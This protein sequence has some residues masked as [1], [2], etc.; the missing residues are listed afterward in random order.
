M[1]TRPSDGA[2]TVAGLAAGS[3]PGHTVGLYLAVEGTTWLSDRTPR[4]LAI[5]LDELR[6]LGVVVHACPRSLA[7]RGLVPDADAYRPLG[8]TAAVRL[9]HRA[10]TLVSL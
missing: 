6:G 9:A 1:V 8:A 5:E 2:V 3:A 4:D 7:G 10:R